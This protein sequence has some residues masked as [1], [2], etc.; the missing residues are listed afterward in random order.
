MQAYTATDQEKERKKECRIFE[1]S[2]DINRAILKSFSF[3]A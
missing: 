2:S 3:I 1:I